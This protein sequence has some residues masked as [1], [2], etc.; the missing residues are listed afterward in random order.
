MNL[1]DVFRQSFNTAA[2]LQIDKRKTSGEEIVA[3][4]DHV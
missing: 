1:A 2:T 4:M 3:K